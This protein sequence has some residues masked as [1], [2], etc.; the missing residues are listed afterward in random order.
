[1]KPIDLS[2]LQSL[3]MA[4]VERGYSLQDK[5]ARFA[6]LRDR[7]TNGTAPR[8]VSSFQLFQTPPALAGELV[9][10]LGLAPGARVL[11][12]SAGLG[13]LL[14]ALQPFNPAEVVAVESSPECAGELFRQE[15]VGVRLVQRDFLEVLPGE[16]GE[17]DAV[18]MNPPF[19][20]RADIRH[21]LHAREFL[22][23]GGRL[24]ALC[25]DTLH[26]EKALRG[27]ASSWRVIPPGAFS[28]EGTGVGVVLLTI[29][30]GGV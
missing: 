22:R 2:R 30:K 21:I 5:A 24:A 28:C 8:A 10:L 11:E 15:R 1:M 18:A 19:H 26:R 9:G 13:R 20:L 3:R 7:H 27:L 6:G 12:P 25:M 29:E 4:N 16:L 17:F 23:P 14:D